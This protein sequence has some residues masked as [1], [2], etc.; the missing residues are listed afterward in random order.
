[1]LEYTKLFEAMVA[2]GVLQGSFGKSELASLRGSKLIKTRFCK[3]IGYTIDS[4]VD[5][6]ID[7]YGYFK[8]SRGFNKRVAECR[9]DMRGKQIKAVNAVVVH[10]PSIRI[11]KIAMID[12]SLVEGFPAFKETILIERGFKKHV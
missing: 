1:M 7:Y 6:I 2:N 8:R 5:F 9:E 3:F 10:F 12:S 11:E 4:D